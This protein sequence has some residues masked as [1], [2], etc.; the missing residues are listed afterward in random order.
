MPDS[1]VHPSKYVIS[2]SNAGTTIVALSRITLASGAY[3]TRSNRK[4]L[5]V[6]PEATTVKFL[7]VALGTMFFNP[8]ISTLFR[9]RVIFFE[10]KA[11]PSTK[12]FQ[13]GV[14]EN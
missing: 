2:P 1:G 3:S 5:W 4:G 13:E 8:Q 14:V 12:H 11:F 10:V 7:G 6:V 9:S